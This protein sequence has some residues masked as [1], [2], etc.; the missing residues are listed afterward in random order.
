MA[1]SNV[2]TTTGVLTAASSPSLPKVHQTYE[3][4]LL[5]RENR[6]CPVYR[7]LQTLN[8]GILF[9]GLLT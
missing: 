2:K 3:A 7:Y 4:A 8:P 5:V 6:S 1:A 9:I